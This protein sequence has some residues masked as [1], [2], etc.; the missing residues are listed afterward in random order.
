MTIPQGLFKKSVTQAYKQGATQL[1]TFPEEYYFQ[2]GNVMHKVSDPESLQGFDLS[3]LPELPKNSN[4]ASWATQPFAKSQS[5]AN[6]LLPIGQRNLGMVSSGSSVQ[7]QQPP[8]QQQTTAQ[9]TTGNQTPFS[10]VLTEGKA[11]TDNQGRYYKYQ[12]SGSSLAL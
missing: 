2:V 4:F 9:P 5:M 7:T 10:G 11:Y 3:Q 12:I 8:T 1:T 6:E